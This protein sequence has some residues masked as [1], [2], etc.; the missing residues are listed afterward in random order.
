[1]IESIA[2]KRRKTH[3][4]FKLILSL[5]LGNKNFIIRTM[6]LVVPSTVVP[7]TAV[8]LLIEAGSRSYGTSCTDK[9]SITGGTDTR[10]DT[11][12][13]NMCDTSLLTQRVQLQLAHLDQCLH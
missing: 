9:R 10:S 6:V 7:S 5:I 13:H 3:D 4:A 12:G 8:T 2:S 11:A 1:M